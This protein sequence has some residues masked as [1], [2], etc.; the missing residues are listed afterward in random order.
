MLKK[1]AMWPEENPQGKLSTNKTKYLT[2]EPNG[3][4][5]ILLCTFCI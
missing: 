4:L 1:H 3:A 2:N 5:N